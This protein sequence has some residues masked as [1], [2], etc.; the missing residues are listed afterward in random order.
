VRSLRRRS[1]PTPGAKWC[2]TGPARRGA[3]R[4]PVRRAAPT[5]SCSPP[6]ELTPAGRHLQ[7]SAAASLAVDRRNRRPLLPRRRARPRLRRPLRGRPPRPAHA[8]SSSGMPVA[9]DGDRGTVQLAALPRRTWRSLPTARARAAKRAR[10]ACAFG[11]GRPAGRR[12][13]TAVRLRVLVNHREPARP[14][15]LRRADHTDGLGLAAH[16]VPL[17]GAARSSPPRTSSSASTAAC[18]S[19]W[20]AK[21]VTLRTLDIGGDKQPVLLPDARTRTNPGPRLA[22]HP[23]FPWSGRICCACNCAPPCAP[24]TGHDLRL[25][26]PMVASLEDVTQAKCA[27][28]STACARLARRT[29]LRPGRARQCPSA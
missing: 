26:L 5:K 11:A 4:V 15:H 23:Q 20:P 9:V 21:P 10:K 25:L 6:A 29:G 24:G 3:R 14:R 18:S 13:R 19:A 28:S 7:S 12:P 1:S 16:R 8:A 27:P 22:R 17:H 2:S